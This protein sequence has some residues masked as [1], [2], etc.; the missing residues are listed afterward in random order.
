MADGR[1]AFGETHLFGRPRLHRV[2]PPRRF[3]LVWGNDEDALAILLQLGM[4][5]GVGGILNCQWMQ[6]KL[7]LH[8]LQK[9][10]TWLDQTDPDDMTGPF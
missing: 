3:R 4:L 1:I 9:I 10:V 8:P 6:I 2:S 7:P 5:V